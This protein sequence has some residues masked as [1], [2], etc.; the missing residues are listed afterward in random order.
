MYDQDCRIKI[1]I[2]SQTVLKRGQ[3]N[4]KPTVGQ[5]KI[6]LFCGIA[7]PLSQKNV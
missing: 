1:S 6:K 3:K 2:K 4:A 7:I 5:E